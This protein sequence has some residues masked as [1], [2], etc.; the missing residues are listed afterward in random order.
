MGTISD[1][2][3]DSYAKYYSQTEHLSIDKITVLYE[4]WVIFNSKKHKR[5]RIKIYNL[6]DSNGYTY[7]M[8]A[9]LG[10][11]RKCATGTMTATHATVA[12]LTRIENVGHKLYMDDFY[13]S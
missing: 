12:G 10:K 7:N 4:G 6:C 2:L 1:K 9:H 8:R 13:F 3:T 5:F 11:D